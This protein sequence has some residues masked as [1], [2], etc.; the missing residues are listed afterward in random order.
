MTKKRVYTT[1]T[2]FNDI[3]LWLGFLSGI[4]IFLVCLSGTI[5][6]YEKEIEAFFYNGISIKPEGDRKSIVELSETITKQTSGTI[7]GVVIPSEKKEPFE[8]SVKK[9]ANDR[10]GA[11]FLVDP[12]TQ[13]IVEPQKTAV[14]DF[15]FSM[16]KLH[17]WLLLDSKIGRPIVGIATIIFLILSI[18][19]LVLW[20]PKKLKW[21]NLKHGFKIKT[22]AK[23]KRINHDLHNT[24]GFYACI[25]ILI[26]GITGLC[27]SF[28]GYRDGLSKVLGT[29][30]FGNRGGE[31]LKINSEL[32]PLAPTINYD[33]AIAI[34]NKELN[35]EGKINISFPNDQN[36][37]FTIRKYNDKSWSTVAAD[38]LIINNQGIVLSKKMYSDIPTNQK[39]ANAI[40]PI[41]TGEIFGGISKLLYFLACLIATSLPI[42]GTL[43]WWNKLKKNKK[44][45]LS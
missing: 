26:M 11:K 33:Q 12:Y 3:H 45:Y 36:P 31:S 5:L 37:L 9:N 20:F 42:T 1:R 13:E 4:I 30:V 24:L 25:F 21:K 2:F 40:K 6:T 7:T 28:E 23:W 38:A 27:W 29:K 41:H 35:Y 8:F 19:G 18:T 32:N 34:V 43:I 22:T 17:R 10:R 16:F 15:M 39:I 14:D 44:W